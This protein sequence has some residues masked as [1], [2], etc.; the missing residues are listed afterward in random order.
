MLG[1]GGLK[2]S[3]SSLSLMFHCRVFNVVGL[4]FDYLSVWLLYVFVVVWSSLLLSVVV[5]GYF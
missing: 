4:V 3:D 5:V 2:S 1:I